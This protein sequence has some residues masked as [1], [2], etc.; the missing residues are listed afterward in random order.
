MARTV[1]LGFDAMDSHLVRTWA[2]EGKLPNLA[3]VI[4]SW[5]SATTL[6]PV[7]LLVGGL[8]PN[9]WSQSGPAHHGSYC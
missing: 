2:S 8:W 4:D 9:F 7:G 6:N 5:G 1:F 3:G